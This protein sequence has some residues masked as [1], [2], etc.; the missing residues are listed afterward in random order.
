MKFRLAI[1][2]IFLSAIAGAALD[3]NAFTFTSYNLNL[4]IEPEQQRLGAYGK[5]ILRNDSSTSQKTAALQIS[6]SLS[7]RA[8]QS[9][10]KALQFVMQP[11]ESDIDHTGELSEA[12]VT[13]PKEVPPNG[14]IDLDIRYEGI[15]PLDTTRL[16]RIGTP[17]DIAAHTDW[18]QISPAFTAVRGV[19]YV[20]WYPVSMDAASLS[21]GDSVFETIAGWKVRERSAQMM[22]SVVS[23][24]EGKLYASGT[25]SLAVI[26]PAE[27]IKSAAST[28]ITDLSQSVPTFVAANFLE[29]KEG[30]WASIAYTTGYETEAKSYVQALS[31]ADSFVSEMVKPRPLKILQLPDASAASFAA[32]GLLLTPLLPNLTPSVESLL[33]YAAARTSIITQQLWLREGLSHFAQ[34]RWVEQQKGRQ[35]AIDYLNAHLP[36]LLEIEKE[37]Q[38]S[39]TG[40]NKTLPQPDRSLTSDMDDIYLQTKSMFV[41]WLLKEMLGAQVIKPLMFDRFQVGQ[42]KNSQYLQQLLQVTGRDLSWFFDDWVYHDRGLPDFKVASVYTS[43]TSAGYLLTVTVE[44]LGAAGAEVPVTVHTESGPIGKRL[45]VRG[46]SKASIR[47][48]TTSAADEVV[49]NDGSVPE[50]DMSNNSYAIPPA[51]V[52]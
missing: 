10:G 28:D 36:A 20:V 5:I 44:N 32:E 16:T 7:W 9:G 13:L 38:T 52:K 39:A 25:A 12:I 26:A 15:I 24:A 14:S 31:K 40:A 33:I 19:G 45:E 21:D 48:E 46:K 49:V 17:K 35:A 34:V 47:I 6:S 29:Q 41:F 42:D 8:I 37:A 50:S 22:L 4:R 27:E 51:A 2:F 18:D 1:V 11:Y 30:D 23:T 43:K 3:R